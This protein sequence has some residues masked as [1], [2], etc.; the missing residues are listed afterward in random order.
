[1]LDN[2]LA[3]HDWYE[4]CACS[5]RGRSPNGTDFPTMAAA[6]QV[7]RQIGAAESAS[8]AGTQNAD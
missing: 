8:K 1:M 5:R 4:R 2:C 7:D 3:L 6:A